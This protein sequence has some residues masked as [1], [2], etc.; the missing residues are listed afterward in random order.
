MQQA[1]HRISRNIFVDE[2][3]NGKIFSE[4]LK[5][6]EENILSILSMTRLRCDR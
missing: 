5:E 4:L 2:S 6:V 1:M 3:D